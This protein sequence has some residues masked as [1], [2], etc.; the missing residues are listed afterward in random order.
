V[1]KRNLLGKAGTGGPIALSC[2]TELSICK[3]V[4]WDERMMDDIS[5]ENNFKGSGRGLIEVLSWH[6]V[7]RKSK[8]T[9]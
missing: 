6:L 8:Q 7:G 9:N 5:T 1:F 3:Y 4:P 2:I